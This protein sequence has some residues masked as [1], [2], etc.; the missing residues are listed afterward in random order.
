MIINVYWEM[1]SR[2]N[3]EGWILEEVGKIRCSQLW[4]KHQCGLWWQERVGED[5]VNVKAIQDLKLHGFGCLWRDGGWN[6]E[7]LG[8]CVEC[9]GK[10][11]Y[12][13]DDRETNLAH[14]IWCNTTISMWKQPIHICHCSGPGWGSSLGNPPRTHETQ[15]SIRRAEKHT[16]I[17]SPRRELWSQGLQ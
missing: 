3:L 9:E 15:S 2:M 11:G 5:M 6:L 7:C 10:S 16:A 12:L 14:C 13:G 8:Y 17:S 1:L 4:W